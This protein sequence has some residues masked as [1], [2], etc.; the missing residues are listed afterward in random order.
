MT[1][2]PFRDITAAPSLSAEPKSESKA[3]EMENARRPPSIREC[4]PM[5]IA[6]GLQRKSL[7]NQILIAT[8][9]YR[10]PSSQHLN[11]LDIPWNDFLKV[12]VLLKLAFYSI[13]I[14]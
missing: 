14:G 7:C 6:D 8:L 9:F 1:I 5:S 12:F 11:V 3:T 4:P 2:F 13:V 10:I